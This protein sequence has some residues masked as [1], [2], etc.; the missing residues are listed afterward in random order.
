MLHPSNKKPELG[1]T[2]PVSNESKNDPNQSHYS[3]VNGRNGS[4]PSNEL[5]PKQNAHIRQQPR[6]EKMPNVLRSRKSWIV[7]CL[8]PVLD[9]PGKYTKV[10]YRPYGSKQKASVNNP[11]SWGDFDTAVSYYQNNEWVTGIGLVI[12]DGLVGVDC[13]DCIDASGKIAPWAQ[14]IIQSLNSYTEYSQSKTGT[15]TLAWGAKP[16][17]R[18]KSPKSAPHKVEM[19]GAS[20]ARFFVMTGDVLDGLN[21]I[22]NRQEE[23][24]AVHNKYLPNEPKVEKARH[25]TITTFSLTDSE[26]IQKAAS[27]KNGYKFA[28]L[29]SGDT[30]E[31]GDDH[32]SA[33]LALC[34]MLSFWTQ[35]D[36][37]RIDSLFRH[38][39]L[40]RSKW[41][42][43]HS[44]DGRTYGEMT[45][46]KAVASTTDVYDPKRHLEELTPISDSPFPFRCDNGGLMNHWLETEGPNWLFNT[47]M[48]MW[49]GWNGKYWEQQSKEYMYKTVVQMLEDTN[50]NVQGLIK[51]SPE[52]DKIEKLK[53]YE[54]LT[55]LSKS[56]VQGIGFLIKVCRAIRNED[57]DK[58]N[59]LNLENGVFDLDS[60]KL[61][62]RDKDSRFTYCLPYSFKPDATAPKWEA[63]IKQVLVTE[64]GE[65]DHS[66][67]LFLQ[68]F[69]GYSLTNDTS[70]ETAVLLFGSGGNGKSVTTNVIRAL[71]GSLAIN[72]DFH[73][74]GKSGN[75]DLAEIDNRRVVFSTELTSETNIAEG[76]F[77]LIVSGE[78]FNARSIYGTP[79]QVSPVAKI[80]WCLNELPPIRDQSNALWRR[81]IVIP[82]NNTFHKDEQDHTLTNKLIQE[83]PGIFNWSLEGLKRLRRNGQFTRAA[84]ASELLEQFKRESNPLLVWMDTCT[85]LTS[86]PETSSAT[87]FKAYQEWAE[88]NG[89]PL[90]NQT[91]FGRELKNNPRITHTEK[92][93]VLYNLKLNVQ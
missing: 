27:A 85:E 20:N 2:S 78:Q 55:R 74:L 12:T 3:T 71:L 8:E 28:Q 57:F 34:N 32:S 19:Y 92:R 40:Y 23:I 38:S 62:A 67:A 5:A 22:E 80:W 44:A 89:Y 26:I 47:T 13:D 42:D 60:F 54:K 75:Y 64:S 77:K 30:G 82:F 39:G 87:L 66:L 65:P 21:Q 37:I 36:A 4:T 45:V 88:E 16:E 58:G 50:A 70:R 18:C 17:G 29:W 73:N 59:H 46:E 56:K 61:I 10:P 52:S 68:E 7:W 41:D 63:F 49:H 1:A 84:S 6:F 83:L 90:K 15:H 48:Q 25:T 86:Y 72:V 33:D 53:A 14:D 51:S 93:K 31:Y 24:T 11:N 9:E 76:Y 43:K 91:S 81:L 79:F 35:R 69:M